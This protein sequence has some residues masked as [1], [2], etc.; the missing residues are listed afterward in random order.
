MMISEAVSI[1]KSQQLAGIDI[2]TD[3]NY[4]GKGLASFMEEKYIDFCIQPCW[5]LTS[6]K[7]CSLYKIL[8]HQKCSRWKNNIVSIFDELKESITYV[9]DIVKQFSISSH[10]SIGVHL[11]S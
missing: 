2:V 1:F 3:S 6:M 4:R 5:V 9:K 11:W 10:F 8:I 7:I